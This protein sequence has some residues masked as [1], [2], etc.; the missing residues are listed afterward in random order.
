[1]K[2]AE[3]LGDYALVK[4]TYDHTIKEYERFERSLDD[5]EM[6]YLLRPHRCISARLRKRNKL[7]DWI[8]ATRESIKGLTDTLERHSVRHKVTDNTKTYYTE[9]HRISALRSE[10]DEFFAENANADT[11]LDRIALVGIENISKAERHI[12]EKESKR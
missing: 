3:E 5:E 10:V 12:L 7:V 1:M 9:P 8:W 2:T 4:I 6:E 11:V